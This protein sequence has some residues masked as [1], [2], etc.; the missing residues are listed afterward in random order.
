MPNTFVAT[1]NAA[2]YCGADV[3]FVDIDPRTYLMSVEALAEKLETAERSGTLPKVVAPV[4]FAG[5]S[6]DMAAIG[7]LGR[8]YGFR[9]LEDAAHAIGADY[10]DGKVGDCR[11]SDIA[12]FSFHPVKVVTTGEGGALSTNDPT[13]ATRLAYLRTHGIT[14]DPERIE[15]ADEGPW[16]Y[17]QQALGFNYRLTDIQA[18]LGV[19]QMK[20]LD[21]FIARRRELAARYDR[22]LSELPLVTPWQD[23]HGR[24]AFH[25]YP[26]RLRLERLNQSRREIFEALRAA[27]IGV[28]VHYIPVHLQPYYRRL[29]FKEGRFPGGGT[30]LRGGHHASTLRCHDRRRAG[31]RDRLPARGVRGNRRPRSAVIEVD[32]LIL[33]TVQFGLPYGVSH[34]GGAVA[35]DEVERILTAAHSAGVRTLDTAAAYGESERVIGSV[36]AALPFEI[37]TKTLP[38]GASEPDPD[39]L[40]AIDSAFRASLD[41]LGRQRVA[42]LLVHDVRNLDGQGGAALWAQLERYRRDGLA[43]KIGVSV[44]DAA[45][46]EALAAR[47]PI[48]IVQLPLNVFDQ[49]STLSGVLERLAAG[50]IIVHARSPLLQGL[51]LMLPDELPP[52]LQHARP[53]VEFWRSACAAAGVTPLAA[54]LGLRPGNAGRLRSG[55]RSPFE[56]SSCPMPRRPSAAGHPSL[57][58]VRPRRPRDD[59]SEKVEAMRRRLL[60]CSSCSS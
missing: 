51:L 47:F 29:G 32:R 15:A 16:Y 44:Y 27:G 60:S 57:G 12:A 37:V 4:H 31:Y 20:R 1:A 58:V 2:R 19:S 30:I 36:A 48:E 53:A 11:Y 8:R 34:R 17:E 28:Q 24:S 23:P 42:A 46:A 52:A 10:R 55:G 45:E 26:I 13:L 41:K 22:L 25:L 43:G 40:A 9:I 54:A 33:G 56:R 21:A 18:A 50:G 39:D 49:R 59:R 35:R 3:A 5:Q 7:D 38:L 6:C 14:R